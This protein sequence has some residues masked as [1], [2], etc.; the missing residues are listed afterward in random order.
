ML[1]GGRPQRQEQQRLDPA[2]VGGR[3]RPRR[4]RRGPSGGE[5]RGR[6]PGFRW[7]DRGHVGSEAWPH[8]DR[9]DVVGSQRPRPRRA[10]QRRPHAGRPRAGLHRDP[11]RVVGRRGSQPRPLGRC[12]AE[13]RWHGRACSQGGGE[14]EQQ[15]LLWVD[16]PHVVNDAPLGR[17]RPASR[18]VQRRPGRADRER[19]RAL[20]PRPWGPRVEGGVGGYLECGLGVSRPLAGCGA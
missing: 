16:G 1:Q 9:E 11:A 12:R 4:R 20:G 18:A 2:H 6:R 10:G 7:Q 13:R 17:P 5:G 14:R 15:G 19:G 3:K 8:H